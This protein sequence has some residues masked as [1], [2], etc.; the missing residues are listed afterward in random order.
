MQQTQAEEPISLQL[1]KARQVMLDFVRDPVMEH[2]YSG[3]TS[4][5]TF[6]AAANGTFLADMHPHTQL[7]MLARIIDGTA[8]R[9]VRNYTES[10]PKDL[11]AEHL[12]LERKKA[13]H[14]L[15]LYHA[16]WELAKVHP[17]E[18]PKVKHDRVHFEDEMHKA[19]KW[20][21]SIGKPKA[22]YSP[23]QQALF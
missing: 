21:D 3:D 14:K 16:A 20:V 8:S 5:K 6:A 23:A 4:W 19:K 13:S 22:R 12:K 9:L 7:S 2:R 1:G 15:A 17:G 18:T 10:I 11:L